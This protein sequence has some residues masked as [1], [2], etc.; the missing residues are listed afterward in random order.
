MSAAAP[1]V[2]VD[3]A[4]ALYRPCGPAAWRIARGKYRGDPMFTALLDPSLLPD[5]ARIL[6]LGCGKGLVAA[7]L[8][9]AAALCREAAWPDTLPR[10]PMYAAYHGI[11]RVPGDVA[12]AARA[13]A[14]QPHV[15]VAIGDLRQSALPSADVVLLLDVLHYLEPQ[16]QHRLLARVRD[17]LPPDGLLLLRVGDAAAGAGYRFS[18]VVDRLVCLARGQP[19]RLYGRSLVA[20]CQLL[21][22]LD[23]DVAS[24]PMSQGTPF[25]NAVLL[26][27][28]R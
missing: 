4:A 17:A 19:T 21:K 1:A 28:P 10:P 16:A 2:L 22:Q 20:W 13:L 26:A 3:R 9:A 7:W 18:T 27:R 23:L 5:R 14:G 25:A 12:I 24:R 8:G 15:A 6:D 11:E